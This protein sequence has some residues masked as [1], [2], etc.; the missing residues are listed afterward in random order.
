MIWFD[1]K[2]TWLRHATS[3]FAANCS[4]WRWLSLIYNSSPDVTVDECLVP[5]KDRCPF[6]QYMLRKPGKCGIKIQA[7]C[8]ASPSYVWNMQVH[9]DKPACGDTEEPSLCVV[10]DMTAGLRS[11]IIIWDHFSTWFSLERELVLRKLTMVG[12]VRWNK[13]ELPPAPVTT[14]DRA[15]FSSKFASEENC[16]ILSQKKQEHNMFSYMFRFLGISG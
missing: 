11:H 16:V 3:L 8:D 12:T 4:F 7:A 10:L 15:R 5:F 6:K 2:Y 14:K 13:P 9:K 1:S